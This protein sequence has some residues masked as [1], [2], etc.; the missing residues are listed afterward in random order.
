M[1]KLLKPNYFIIPLITAA[2]AFFGSFI[3]AKGMDWYGLLKL[4]SITPAGGLISAAWTIIFILATI[5]ALIFY[6]RAYRNLR[7]ILVIS[8]FLINAGLNVLWSYL[9]FGLHLVA[10]SILEMLFLEATVIALIVLIRHSSRLAAILLYPYALWVAFVT[11]L[12]WQ[13]LLLNT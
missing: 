7:F 11:Y 1:R 4:P 12:A 5:S 8:L 2:V 3:T 6:N 13:I 10:A 9:F